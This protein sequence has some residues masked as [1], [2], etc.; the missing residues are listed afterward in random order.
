MSLFP[1]PA[2]DELTITSSEK[3]LVLIKVNDLYGKLIKE[4]NSNLTNY[5]TMD[6]SGLGD[7]I[8]ILSILDD[9]H[10]WHSFRIVHI[11]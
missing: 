9:N 1:N 3:K 4:V 5:F 2:I 11:K 6:V 7:G 8:Y 10:D